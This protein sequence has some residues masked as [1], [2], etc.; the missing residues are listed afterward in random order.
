[1]KM[2][3][4]VLSVLFLMAAFTLRAQQL[5]L[6]SQYM[7]NKFVLNPAIAGN[8]NYVP[9]NLN[10]RKQW[11]GIDGAPVTQSL[12]AHGYVGGNVGLGGFFFNDVT[13]PTRRTGMSVS[14]AYHVKLNRDFSRRLSFGLSGL[15]FQHFVDKDKLTTDQPD[16]PAITNGFNNEFC[17]DASFGV[18][19][20][21]TNKY[22]LGVSVQNLLEVK[23][24]LFD[25]SRDVTNPVERTYY[26]HGGYM[27][28]L[29]D[30]FVFEP[31][32]LMQ[33][34]ESTPMQFDFNG[35]FGYKNR[36]WLGGSY[37]LKDAVVMMFAL[38]L[39]DFSI[40]YSYDLTTSD[41]KDYTQGSHEINLTY[42]IFR[43]DVFRNNTDNPPL[44]N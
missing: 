2:K 13:G 34:Q 20:S 4:I 42:R 33:F 18:Y 11:A 15:F 35:R 26:A 38:N 17:P 40:G 44:F 23:K 12:S 22:F 32:F 30:D 21:E 29:G 14:F 36:V 6:T 24:D 16:D 37:R 31:S 41:I 5:S 28:N 10:I 8:F 43:K 3:N 1:M 25:L 9:V 19:L 7:M 27:F 39:G